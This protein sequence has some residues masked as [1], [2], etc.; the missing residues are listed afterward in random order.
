MPLLDIQPT[1][2]VV[3][4]PI[5]SCF[6]SR[7]DQGADLEFAYSPTQYER[8]GGG[9]SEFWICLILFAHFAQLSIASS[10]LCRSEKKPV[11]DSQES[12]GY[13]SCVPPHG[14]SFAQ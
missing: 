12:N 13:L 11:C 7:A 3:G 5:L 4:M 10:I 14:S 2:V 1:I 6:N 8:G 9:Y